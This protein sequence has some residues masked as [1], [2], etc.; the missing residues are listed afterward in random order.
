MRGLGA[1]QVAQMKARDARIFA[2]CQHLRS[3]IDLFEQI[4]A[5]PLKTPETLVPEAQSVPPPPPERVALP[6]EK[7]TYNLKE[8]A[9]A[10]GIGKTTLYKAIAER[11]LRAIKLGSRTLI[12]SEDLRAWIAAQP[13]R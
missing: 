7:L 11:R 9:T 3:A 8:A 2:L 6:V 1:F 4:A 10:L 13:M 5:E 12:P